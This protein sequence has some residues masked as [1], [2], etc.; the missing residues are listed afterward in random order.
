M[1]LS[2]LRSKPQNKFTFKVKDSMTQQLPENK[3]VYKEC[4]PFS[5]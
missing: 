4:R 5:F 1:N 3:E 2:L